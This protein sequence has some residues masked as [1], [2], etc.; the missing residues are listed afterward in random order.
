MSLLVAVIIA[1]LLA[2]FLTINRSHWKGIIHI[3]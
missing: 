2:V 3:K 1:D